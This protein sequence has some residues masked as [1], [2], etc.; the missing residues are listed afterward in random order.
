MGTGGPGGGC[1]FSCPL[2]SGATIQTDGKDAL[3]RRAY[4]TPSCT[5]RPS[6][7]REG[8]DGQLRGQQTRWGAADPGVPAARPVGGGPGG[9]VCL[10]PRPLTTGQ[11]GEPAR[12]RTS[13]RGDRG[14]CP[15]EATRL[16]QPDLLIWETGTPRH[17]ASGVLRGPCRMRRARRGDKRR[18]RRA[19]GGS[20]SRGAPVSESRRPGGESPAPES[21]RP[22]GEKPQTSGPP[23][24]WDRKSETPAWAELRP[25][26]WAGAA[27][28]TS[29]ASGRLAAPGVAWRVAP[30]PPP[31][32]CGHPACTVRP[33]GPGRAAP[34]QRDQPGPP[35]EAAPHSSLCFA[36]CHRARQPGVMPVCSLPS[37]L[38]DVGSLRTAFPSDGFT[39]HLPDTW[40][41][42]KPLLHD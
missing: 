27:G 22:G 9:A 13:G 7:S 21:R 31:G 40:T 18:A 12:A 28:R 30:S 3:R 29:A 23:R 25:V 10:E 20:L 41:L 2:V 42:D 36:L 26:A 16:S 6:V 11:R 39:C 15:R 24:L 14:P 19:R 5:C 4:Q 35:S 38:S 32:L 17:R 8:G 33:Q 37:R 1:L 34:A